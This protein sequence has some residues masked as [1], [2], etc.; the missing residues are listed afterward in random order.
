MKELQRFV[1]RALRGARGPMPTCRVVLGGPAQAIE[2]AA[3]QLQCDLIVMGTSGVG[4]AGRVF[5]G[6]TTDRVL[7]G[8]TIPVLAV[9][10]G[11][12]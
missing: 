2:K 1:R 9:P 7:R 3:K 8:T 11:R 5:F 12:R 10:A 4:A 6:S